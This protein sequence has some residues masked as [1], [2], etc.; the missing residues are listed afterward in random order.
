MLFRSYVTRIIVFP[1]KVSR[2]ELRTHKPIS[3]V[4]ARAVLPHHA[5]VSHVFFFLECVNQ[6]PQDI[7]LHL[8]DFRPSSPPHVKRKRYFSFRISVNQKPQHIWSAQVHFCKT[9][10]PPM[11]VSLTLFFPRRC[12]NQKPLDI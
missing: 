8:I 6:R 5:F 11:R 2:P 1:K 4:F 12:I 7:D 10:P 3:P 9:H